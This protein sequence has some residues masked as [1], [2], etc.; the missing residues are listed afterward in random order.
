[1]FPDILIPSR[2][3]RWSPTLGASERRIKQTRYVVLFCQHSMD[4]DDVC[5][6]QRAALDMGPSAPQLGGRG[7][8][9]AG[10]LGCA[11]RVV[12][13]ARIGVDGGLLACPGRG[14][15]EF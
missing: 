9:R 13:A 4:T 10:L 1:M 7:A 11:G 5:P 15:G 3:S 14:L 12:A 2:A 6:P 8:A